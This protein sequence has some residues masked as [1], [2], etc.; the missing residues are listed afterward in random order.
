MQTTSVIIRSSVTASKSFK[1]QYRMV[2]LTPDICTLT[3]WWKV[4]VWVE[5]RERKVNTR[6]PTPNKTTNT[7]FR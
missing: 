7:S 5:M 4:S 6:P 3:R 2:L 1:K